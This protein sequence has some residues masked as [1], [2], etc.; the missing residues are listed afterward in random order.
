MNIFVTEV[1]ARKL[2]TALESI[3]G[4]YVYSGAASLQL[5]FPLKAGGELRIMMCDESRPGTV[6]IDLYDGALPGITGP[7]IKTGQ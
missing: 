5:C 3:N 2:L 6:D 7:V 4:G 1:G